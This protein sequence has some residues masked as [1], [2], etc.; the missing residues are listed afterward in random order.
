MVS[1]RTTLRLAGAGLLGL[2]GCTDRGGRT[3][4][5]TQSDTPDGSTPDGG[6]PTDGTPSETPGD[7]R[8][9]VEGASPTWTASLGDGLVTDPVYADGHVAVVVGTTVYGVDAATG[10]TAWTFESPVSPEGDYGR[11][12]AELV[13]HDGVLY[14]LVGISVGTGAHDH[15]LHALTP[16]GEERWTYESGTGG[17]HTVVGFGDEAVVLGTSDDAIG[18]VDSGGHAAIAVNLADGRERWRAETADAMGGSVGDDFVAVELYGGV[19]CFDVATGERRFQFAPDGDD[20]IS[21][22]A[23]GGGRAFVGVDRYEGDEPTMHALFAETGAMDWSLSGTVVSSL[24]YRGDLYVG[25]ETV[26]RYGPTG[27]RRWSF[28]GGGLLT[29]VPFDP[30]ALYTNAD[31][32]VVKLSRETGAGLWT[33]DATDLAIPRARGGDAVVSADGQARTVF[34]HSAG[35]GSE[36]WRASLPGEYPPTPAAGDDGAILATVDGELAMV[37]F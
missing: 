13:R 37:P 7:S 21:A 34:A 29:G 17:F 18:P 1:R 3:P 5:A 2:A 16:A 31:S 28:D 9:D 32:S 12:A 22:T 35:D 25:G 6:G 24:R 19:D 14:A 15:V 26:A 10:E 8:I 11:P 20:R 36:L 4:T 27:P 33:A 23:V 30:D